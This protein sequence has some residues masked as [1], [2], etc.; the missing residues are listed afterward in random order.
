MPKITI[1]LP[2]DTN[3]KLKKQAKANYRSLTNYITVTL[4][5]IADNIDKPDIQPTPIISQPGVIESPYPYSVTATAGLAQTSALSI[6]Q[7]QEQ[8]VSQIKFNKPTVNRELSPE[9]E[10]LR[11]AKLQHQKS[12]L[13][14]QRIKFFKQKSEEI[15]GYTL[16]YIENNDQKLIDFVLNKYPTDESLIE[17]L[18]ELKREDE[19]EELNEDTEQEDDS[20]SSSS[21]EPQ[22][23]YYQK[24]KR[25]YTQNLE[26][27]EFEDLIT[28]AKASQLDYL[29]ECHQL[30][31]F[32]ALGIP[33]SHSWTDDEWRDMINLLIE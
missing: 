13:K 17:F 30:N 8:G 11:Q 12:K 26:S 29:K 5:S 18:R 33:H 7:L 6:E 9:E 2:A 20:S 21:S 27:Y 10:E 22:N 3:E 23:E 31:I 4:I 28:N 32:D 1:D 19:L 15:L 14:Q 16:S 24:I 25:Y